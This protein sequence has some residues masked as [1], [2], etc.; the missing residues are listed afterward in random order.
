LEH[1]ETPGQFE[2]TRDLVAFC[3]LQRHVLTRSNRELE[4]VEG[5][6]DEEEEDTKGKKAKGGEPEEHE[7][8]AWRKYLSHPGVPDGTVFE[9]ERMAVKLRMADARGRVSDHKLRKMGVTSDSVEAGKQERSLKPQKGMMAVVEDRIQLS[10]LQGDF[11]NL[12]NRGK[13]L[14]RVRGWVRIGCQ[15]CQW[16]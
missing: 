5:Q 3:S 14:E 6:D 1:P 8:A 4:V 2:L 13:P 12:P 16:A 9:R 15:L 10:M 11:D 7:I